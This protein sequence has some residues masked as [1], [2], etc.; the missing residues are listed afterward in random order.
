M[1][2]L[3]DSTE[4]NHFKFKSFKKFH[5]LDEELRLKRLK[6]QK[7]FKGQAPLRSN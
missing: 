4:Q 1:A 7:L 3:S 2:F 5:Q 6:N